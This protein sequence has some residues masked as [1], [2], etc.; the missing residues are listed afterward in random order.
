MES[1][2]YRDFFSNFVDEQ[3]VN[4]I[5]DEALDYAEEYSCQGG[6]PGVC[7]AVGLKETENIGMTLEEISEVLEVSRRAVYNARKD[8]DLDVME[9]RG[10][11]S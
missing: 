9:S 1:I 2:D 10:R 8:L 11:H 6:S 5:D 7:V 4:M 3:Y